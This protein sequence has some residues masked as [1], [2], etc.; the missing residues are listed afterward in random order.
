VSAINANQGSAAECHRKCNLSVEKVIHAVS[1]YQP[2]EGAVTQQLGAVT[3]ADYE[4]HRDGWPDKK[5]SAPLK[6]NPPG[7][8][9]TLY[10]ENWLL[11]V[12]KHYHYQRL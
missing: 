6:R 1:A 2:L 4:M 7:T 10:M 5:K 11:I 8:S 3:D 9:E 12:N